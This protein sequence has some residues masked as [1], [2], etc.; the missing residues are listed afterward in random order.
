MIEVTTWV[1]ELGSD[2]RS[3]Q[4]PRVIGFRM[5]R[6]SGRDRAIYSNYTDQRDLGV[7]FN[8]GLLIGYSIMAE[9]INCI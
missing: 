7:E 4:A 6:A 1:N 3:G 9:S 5:N 8:A 2:L